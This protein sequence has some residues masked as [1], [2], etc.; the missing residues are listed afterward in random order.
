MA[1]RGRPRKPKPDTPK[2]PAG[3][4]QG[5]YGRDVAVMLTLTPNRVHWFEYATEREV[6]SQ[7]RC[8][9]RA[10]RQLGLDIIVRKV[11]HRIEVI[12]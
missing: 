7:Y 9:R 3:R 12:T 8:M 4:P 2:R 5:S 1:R 10:V 6:Q 11:R